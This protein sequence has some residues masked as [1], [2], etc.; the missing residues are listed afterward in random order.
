MRLLVK[1]AFI[2]GVLM[3]ISG[4]VSS[5]VWAPMAALAEA[6]ATVLVVAATVW[7]ALRFFGSGRYFQSL[8]VVQLGGIDLD[9]LRSQLI[10]AVGETEL[11]A[12]VRTF[13]NDVRQDRFG[14]QYSVAGRQVSARS[15][16]AATGSQRGLQRTWAVCFAGLMAQASE[17]RDP[18][19][20]EVDART[21]VLRR[22]SRWRR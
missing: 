7:G 19:G 20:Q 22:D 10:A 6:G 18:E 5:A 13:I 8:G 1:C 12:E 3:V 17:W 11:L 2:V 21:A 15:T 4:G 9:V 14:H 16:T